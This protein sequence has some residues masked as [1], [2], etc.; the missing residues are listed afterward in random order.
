MVLQLIA[1]SSSAEKNIL[2]GPKIYEQGGTYFLLFLYLYK[3][4]PT[5]ASS[6]CH[7]PC[8]VLLL[9][10]SVFTSNV[11]IREICKLCPSP[12]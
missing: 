11:I 3:L 2:L 7:F 6:F 9:K 8:T 1:L 5:V 12:G 10:L 4:F